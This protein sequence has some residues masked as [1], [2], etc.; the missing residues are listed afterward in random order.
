MLFLKDKQRKQI[1]NSDVKQCY[2]RPDSLSKWLPWLDYEEDSKT[3]TL[4][5]A[6]SAAAMFEIIGVST[7]AR[8]HEFLQNIKINIQTCINHT[9]PALDNPFILQCFVND[10]GSL[11]HFFKER[12]DYVSDRC[13]DGYERLTENFSSHMQNHLKRISKR[14]GFFEDTQVT[15]SMWS[16][17]IRRIRVFL[18]RR[19]NTTDQYDID[20][21]TEINQVA[22]CF[23]TQML[24][25]GMTVRRCNDDDL[26]AWLVRWFNPRAEPTHGD[27]DVLTELMTLPSPSDRVF[28]HDLSSFLFLS[29]PVSDAENGV[30]WFD[31]LPHRAITV[32]ALRRKPQP[33]H[34]SGE[35][36]I[37]DKLAALIDRFPEGSLLSICVTIQ[38]QDLV[39]NH[40]IKVMN[41]AKGETAEARAAEQDAKDALTYMSH[42][43]YLLPTAITVFARGESLTDLQK[44]TNELNALLLSNGLHPIREKD[45]LLPLDTYIKNLPMN[46]EP[47]RDKVARRSRLMF[48]SDIACLLPFYGRGRGTGNHGMTF[49][50][51]GGEP[52]TFDPLNQADRE[53]N[54]FG[55]VLGPPGSGKSA[56]MVYLLLQIAATYGARI[57]VIEKGGSFKLFG[58][59]CKHFG[60][61]VNRIAIHPKSDV[62][63]P[64]F[65]DAY[66]ML[67]REED[68]KYFQN[69]ES[70]LEKSDE[71][72]EERDL[73]GEMEIKARLMITGGD[74]KEEALLARADRLTIRKAIINAARK[75]FIEIPTEIVLVE[76]VVS[77]LN[78]LSQNNASTKKRRE[79]AKD[80]ADAM[81]LYCQG[82]AGRFF[83]RPGKEWPEA[84]VTILEMGMLADDG[85]EDQLALAYI[86]LM[87]QINGIVEREQYSNRPTFTLGDEAHIIT[88]NALLSIYLVKIVKMWRKLGAWLWL[89]TQNLEDFPDAAKKLL[90]LF[91]WWIAMVCPKEEIE[92]IARFKDLSEEQKAILLAARKEPGKYTEGVILSKRIQCLFRNIP[93]LLALV[94]AMTEKEEKYK[95]ACL[96]KEHNCSELEAVFMIVDS[97]LVER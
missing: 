94:L 15:G 92:Q 81:A 97:L 61:T 4:E 51:R 13:R 40:V 88:T 14:C 41:A 27:V 16:G 23:V 53:M 77:A 73:L 58:D 55:L 31:D 38:P 17:K 33:G 37:G 65:A 9:I 86:G 63:L 62:S 32:D 72:S 29:Q 22:D 78:A 79:R 47:A 11:S 7:E 85:Y 74:K 76:D 10:E 66:E 28:N 44:K 34:F 89:A 35:R 59:Y 50:N 30:W 21:V 56:L 20:P 57:Y 8:T 42:G 69:E 36:E 26:N 91:E 54:A 48:S 80:M 45:E 67:K 1:K 49:F 18:Y 68:K 46:Y 64:P 2:Q 96:M 83:N 24:A 84:D 52:L 12:E 95:R 90:S 75:K 87:N 3:F 39:E 5:D 70:A 43:D 6:Y 82:T 93:P 25:T 60:L 19:R 71:S